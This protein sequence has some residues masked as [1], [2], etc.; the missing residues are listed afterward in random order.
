MHLNIL[1]DPRINK[2]QNIEDVFPFLGGNGMHA[3][4]VIIKMAGNAADGG[5][6]SCAYKL[7]MYHTIT[8]SLGKRA[9]LYSGC[10]QQQRHQ[11][12]YTELGVSL[13]IFAKYQ[14]QLPSM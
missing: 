3:A 9:L 2:L 8:F 5:L 11:R 6:I 4:S 12:L 1:C 7:A 10:L 14:V 13:A